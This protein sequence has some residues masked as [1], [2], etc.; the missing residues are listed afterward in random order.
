MREDE[1]MRNTSAWNHNANANQ[2]VTETEEQTALRSL[3]TEPQTDDERAAKFEVFEK[4]SNK[5]MKIRGDLDTM[6]QET[7]CELPPLP[8]QA[9][10]ESMKKLDTPECRGIYDQSRF[11]FVHDMFVTCSKNCDVMNEIS[12]EIARKIRLIASNSQTECP[13]CLLEFKSKGPAPGQVVV[14]QSDDDEE[15]KDADEEKVDEVC[16]SCMHKICAPCWQQWSQL[17]GGSVFCPICK[18][19]EF[20]NIIAAVEE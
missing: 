11:W 2:V 18:N 16:L 3:R 17:R 12:E 13:I 4:F 8:Q 9:I 5:M 15:K 10:K 14:A 19:T 6:I 7:V 20:L 1:Q